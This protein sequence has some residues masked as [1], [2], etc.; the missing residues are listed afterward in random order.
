MNQVQNLIKPIKNEE[1]RLQRVAG[2]LIQNLQSVETE[3][4]EDDGKLD[5]E[6]SPQLQAAQ[7]ELDN[8]NDKKAVNSMLRDID[9]ENSDKKLMIAKQREQ[10]KLQISRCTDEDQKSKLIEQAEKYEKNIA[11]Q[12]KSDADAQN[13]RL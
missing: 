11:Q 1:E 7:A 12:L 10:L 2:D 8:G 3:P 5:I 9:K 4:R 13:A 6:I